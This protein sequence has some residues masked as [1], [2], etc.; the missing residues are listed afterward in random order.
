MNKRNALKASLLAALLLGSEA[1]AFTNSGYRNILDIGCHADGSVC[2]VTVDG[3][4]VAPSTGCVSNSIRWSGADP[5]G[6]T[7]LSLLYG[8]F[9]AGKQVNFT[10]DAC[11]ATQPTYPTFWW[12]YIKK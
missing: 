3:D 2:Y 5:A 1:A 8:A 11:F 7:V 12:F 9:L 6:K 10:M 4:A